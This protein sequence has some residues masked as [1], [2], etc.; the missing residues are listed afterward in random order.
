MTSADEFVLQLLTDKG[1]L[2]ESTIETARA[3]VNESEYDGSEDTAALEALVADHSI[4]QQQIADVLAEEFNMETVNLADVRVSAEALEIVPF[5]LANRYKVIPLE[6]DDSEAELAIFDP[7][8]MDALDSISHVIKR[9]ITCRVAPLEEIDK[10]IH[11]YYEGAKAGVVDDIFSGME[12]PDAAPTQI[13]LPSGEDASEEEAPIIKY[14]HMVISE[15]LKRRASDIHMEPL[16]KRFRVRYRID[17]VLHEVENPPKRLQPSIVSRI[18]L[19]SNV[20]IA[21]KRVPQDGRIN[22]NVGAKIIDLR[23]STLPTAFGE[24]IVMRIL[25]KE[26]LN[27]GLPQLGFFS[28]DQA[29]FERIIALPDGVFLVTGPT[30]SGKSTTLYSALNCINHPDRKIITVEDPVEYEMPGVNQV[31]VRRDVGMTFSAALRSMLRQAPNIIMVGEIRDKETAEIAINA[32]LTGHMVF[33]TLHTNDAPSAVSRLIDIGIKP[34]LVAAAVRAVLAQ[35]LVR[36]NCP[37][38]R[39]PSEHDEKLLN[40][41]GIRLDQIADASFMK[42]EGCVKCNG[43]GFRGRVG[44]FEMFQVNEELQ[45]M[46]YEDASLVALRDKAREMGMRNMRED[47]IRKIIGGI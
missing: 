42:G 37:S 43:T 27:L 15:A 8:D 3:K 25:D 44:I 2:E 30:G 18:K 13:D 47:G 46:I 32:A 6:V 9:S 12:D 20:S 5:E 21:E 23:L 28:D 45:S 4:N 10:A 11:Q 29:A 17:G 40:S 39:V 38:C 1:L 31:Q 41:L 35:R 33:S 14:V 22:I 34:F 19:M 7:L 26:S 16:E 24:S 36:R